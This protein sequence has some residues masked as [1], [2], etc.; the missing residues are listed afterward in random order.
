MK[1]RKARRGVT[2]PVCDVTLEPRVVAT[3]PACSSR[4]R[5][6]SPRAEP[7]ARAAEP[8]RA[9]SLRPPAWD[10]VVGCSGFALATGIA[11]AFGDAAIE[12]ELGGATQ[13]A[14][15]GAVLAVVGGLFVLCGWLLTASAV[16]GLATKMLAPQRLASDGDV[17]SVRAGGLRARERAERRFAVRDLVDVLV[18]PER[19]ITFT[20]WVVHRKG[21]AFQVDLGMLHERAHRLGALL[22]AWLPEAAVAPDYRGAGERR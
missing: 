22:K 5:R 8:P 16:A 3:C 2:C 7:V 9:I 21:P 6:P 17:V 11:L 19:A 10:L 12:G 13:S 15:A 18:E 4:W 14:F 20:L 1:Q